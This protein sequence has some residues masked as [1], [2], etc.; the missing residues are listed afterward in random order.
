MDIAIDERLSEIF[1]SVTSI[2]DAV[3]YRDG[4]FAAHK[5]PGAFSSIQLLL[6]AGNTCDGERK[7]NLRNEIAPLFYSIEAYNK[8]S[9]AA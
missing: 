3:V 5:T 6:L 2:I 9:K 4:V 7:C 8:F 1:S